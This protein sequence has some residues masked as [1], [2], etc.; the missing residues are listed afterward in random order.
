MYKKAKMIRPTRKDPIIFPE[1]DLF[2]VKVQCQ[3]VDCAKI[4]K[5]EFVGCRNGFQITKPFRGPN[6]I[7][8]F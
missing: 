4:R 3:M 5:K 7:D 8:E 2:I 6:R 1:K